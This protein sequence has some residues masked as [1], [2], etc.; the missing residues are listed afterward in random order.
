M[1]RGKY[2]STNFVSNGSGEEKTKFNTWF[3]VP[4]S[5]IQLAINLNDN[6]YNYSVHNIKS[7]TDRCSYSSSL[8]LKS[9]YL[10]MFA[11]L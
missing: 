1:S 7:I 11:S 10:V 6:S 2:T 9:Y 3:D 4:V 5:I 8:T